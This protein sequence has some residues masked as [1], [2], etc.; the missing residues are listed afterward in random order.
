[1]HLLV[2]V[3]KLS[4]SHVWF[5]VEER[6]E[7][8]CAADGDCLALRAVLASTERLAPACSVAGGIIPLVMHL[9]RSKGFGH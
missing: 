4:A 1:M 6:L 3:G 2:S 7:L 8:N 5:C 9:P